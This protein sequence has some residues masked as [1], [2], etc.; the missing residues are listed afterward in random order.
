MSYQRQCVVQNIHYIR[1]KLYCHTHRKYSLFGF[2]K[3]LLSEDNK[4]MDETSM[5]D[6]VQTI[7]ISEREKHEKFYMENDFLS[8]RTN[9]EQITLVWFDNHIDD[10]GPHAIDI[11]YT[12][13]ILRTVNDYVV[14]FNNESEFLAFVSVSKNETILIVLA[15]SCSTSD[16]LCRLHAIR[17]I[18]SIFIF[19]RNE[20]KY[21][22]LLSEKAYH[23]I[24][25]IFNDQ[26]TLASSINNVIETVDR[27]SAIFALYNTDRQKS[28]RDLSRE[29]GSFLFLQLIKQ[30]IRQM[31][32]SNSTV[33]DSKQEMI[34]KCKLYYR[35]NPKEIQNIDEFD[36]DYNPDNA[37]KWYTRNSF[38]YK[39]INKALRCEDADSLYTYRFYIVDLSALL[40]KNCRILRENI[41]YLTVYRGIKMRKEEMD[42]LSNSVGHHMSCNGYFSSSRQE[43]VAKMYAG[44]GAKSALISE[45]KPLESVLFVI[46]IDLDAY[47][48][49]VLADISHLRLFTDEAEV[50]FDLGTV[51]EIEAFD[52]NIQ[53]GYYICS[54]KPSDKGQTISKGYLDFKREELNQSPDV[55][56]VFGDLL[57]DMG[58][59]QKSYTYFQGLAHR[60]INDPQ[61]HFGIARSHDSLNK[62]DEA[63]F[64][65]K[66]AYDLAMSTDPEWLVLS[67]KICLYASRVHNFSN[68]FEEA[69]AFGNEALKLYKRAGEDE[70]T[71]GIAKVLLNIGNIH[72]L[73]CDHENSLIYFQRSLQLLE[74]IY[75]FDHPDKMTPL[76][77]LSH[78]FYL[79]GEYEKALGYVLEGATT[80]QQLLPKDHPNIAVDATCIGKLLYKLGRYDEALEQFR[81][82]TGIYER[83]MVDSNR[84]YSVMLNNIGK[85]FYQLGNLDEAMIYYQK[86]LASLE[87]LFSSTTPHHVDFAY[88]WKNFGEISFARENY[89]EALMF[90]ERAQKIYERAFSAEVGHR[91]IAKCWFFIAQTN[92]ML[93]NDELSV[94]AFE[95]ALAMWAKN[96]PEYH[97]DLALC[98]E[99]MGNFYERRET[100]KHLTTH[101][102]E[103]A[104]TIYETKP[105]INEKQ[106]NQIRKKL[107]DLKNSQE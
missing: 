59:W 104:L 72:F 57:H 93:K 14:L 60:R 79:L 94:D 23:K 3:R 67:A 90:F 35:G 92:M 51:F 40:A 66:Q 26:V 27:Q 80:T 96:L 25:G 10:L 4:K 30:A 8:T 61:V 95:K 33:V 6:N 105:K 55:E 48:E 15:G 36:K 88:T 28:M 44:I 43:S 21:Q 101:H 74:T 62:A 89:T 56:I 9:C 2:F 91:D 98:H 107:F 84:N 76:C 45:P 97:P 19:C 24:A 12:K 32:E 65:L 83:Q 20:S 82:A 17:G 53:V 81:L 63:L 46:E 22:Y 37:I 106:I 87:S 47:P 103:T 31:L 29:S 34:S 64:H 41:S 85:T 75:P 11:Q 7:G 78:A 13:D 49:L 52:Y 100:M 69:L 18:D 70:N 5:E 68:R 77:S 16:L 71:A 42:R 50:L 58:E 86:A 1:C 54:M 39:L 38:L 102:L 99:S 73:K